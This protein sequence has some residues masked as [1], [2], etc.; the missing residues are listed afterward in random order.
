LEV[1]VGPWVGCPWVVVVFVVVVQTSLLGIGLDF[2]FAV[3][4]SAYLPFPSTPLPPPLRYVPHIVDGE[5]LRSRENGVEDPGDGGGGEEEG[6]GVGT[7]RVVGEEE[8]DG[9]G[10]GGGG[11][12]E[13]DGGEVEVSDRSGWWCR[14]LRFAWPVVVVCGV[15]A[16]AA[17]AAGRRR[18]AAAGSSP[19]ELAVAPPAGGSGV[20]EEVVLPDFEVP[21][22]PLLGG[23]VVGVARG[24][25]GGRGRGVVVVHVAIEVRVSVRVLLGVRVPVPFPVLPH[26]HNSGTKHD[27]PMGIMVFLKVAVVVALPPPVPHSSPRVDGGCGCEG[28]TGG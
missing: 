9:E 25:G 8:G 4:T 14:L 20:L 7:V 3:V 13:R 15:R 17:A 24:G 27:L 6:D 26:L 12:E 5:S 18:A 10:G 21:D 23:G 1:L 11:R 19:G 28:G 22:D 2:L 16:A